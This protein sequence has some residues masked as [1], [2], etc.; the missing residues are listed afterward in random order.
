M[1]VTV[2]YIKIVW[3]C[4]IHILTVFVVCLMHSQAKPP[5]LPLCAIYISNL[6]Q[7]TWPKR[8]LVMV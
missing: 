2:V 6:K 1:Y 8:P 5:L 3:I 4:M 7:C